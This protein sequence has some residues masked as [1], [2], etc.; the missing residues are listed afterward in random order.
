MVLDVGVHDRSEVVEPAVPEQV[1]D[2]HLTTGI[3]LLFLCSDLIGKYSCK[4]LPVTGKPAVHIYQCCRLKGR[5]ACPGHLAGT[6]GI[7]ETTQKGSVTAL[8]TFLRTKIETKDSPNTV[9]K[10]GFFTPMK[11]EHLFVF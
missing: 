11:G 7:K 9:M 1:N 10:S 8:K 4:F 3:K 2:E 6:V 5:K